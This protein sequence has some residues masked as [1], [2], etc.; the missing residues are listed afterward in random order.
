MRERRKCLDS[1]NEKNLALHT[2]QLLPL[3]AHSPD[4]SSCQGGVRPQ[5]EHRTTVQDSLTGVKD[6]ATSVGTGGPSGCTA[7]PTRNGELG[8]DTR[9]YTE[10]EF[11]FPKEG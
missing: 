5:L 4:G 3:R 6:S 9:P 1:R 2:M 11:G 8:W 10:K 7:V